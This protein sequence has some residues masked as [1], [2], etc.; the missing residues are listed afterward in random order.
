MLFEIIPARLKD[1]DD[2]MHLTQA[3]GY[4]ANREETSLWLQSLVHSASHHVFVAV[5]EGKVSA[6]LVV[7]KRLFLE[8]GYKAEITGLVVGENYRRYGIAKALVSAAE[9][10]AKEQGLAKIVVRSNISREDSHLFY[11]AM[12]FRCAKT[13]HVYDKAI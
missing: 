5:C 13:S 4:E 7:E 9:G 2:I 8:S 12:G 10:W 1:A 11:A 6:W 3:L